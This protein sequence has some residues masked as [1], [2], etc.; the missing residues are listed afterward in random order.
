MDSREFFR[1]ARAK[2]ATIQ[3][4]FVVVVSKETGDGGV[5]G[6]MNYV[7]REIAARQIVKDQA[8]LATT[9]QALA[10]FEEDKR[11]R[12]EFEA[13]KWRNRL[14][15]AVIRDEDAAKLNPPAA[16]KSEK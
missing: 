14:Q 13:E 16:R 4:P 10:F 12:E 15:V 5:A 11:I 2:A 6:V 8:E 3:E 1:R 9:E 7:S